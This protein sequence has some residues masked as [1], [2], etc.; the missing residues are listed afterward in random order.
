MQIDG[1]VSGPSSQA[2]FVA[3][4]VGLT[5]AVHSGIFNTGTAMVRGA[6]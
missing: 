1:V 4:I 5:F 3:L 2:A 6:G